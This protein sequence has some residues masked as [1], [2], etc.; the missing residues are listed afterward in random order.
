MFISTTNK[1]INKGI[2]EINLEVLIGQV[3]EER[4][5]LCTVSTDQLK[6][7]KKNYTK[8]LV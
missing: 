5:A 3:I 1:Y 6:I 7:R 2:H 8:T 4:H